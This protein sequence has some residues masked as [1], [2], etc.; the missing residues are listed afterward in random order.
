ME[1]C[2]P[3]QLSLHIQAHVPSCATYVETVKELQRP[4]RVH[5]CYTYMYFLV[6]STKIMILLWC[7]V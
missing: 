2:Y 4:E 1:K 5:D 6:K 3:G 7:R